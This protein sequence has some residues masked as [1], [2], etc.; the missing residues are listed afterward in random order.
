MNNE[1]TDAYIFVLGTKFGFERDFAQAGKMVYFQ[2]VVEALSFYCSNTIQIQTK[3]MI[4]SMFRA[5]FCSRYWL[6][7]KLLRKSKLGDRD[8]TQ[9]LVD[10][11]VTQDIRQGP[12]DIFA[13]SKHSLSSLYMIQ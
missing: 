12:E 13:Q 5:S 11:F 1:I 3:T 8:G 9:D 6:Y 4:S 10:I 7:L 2:S